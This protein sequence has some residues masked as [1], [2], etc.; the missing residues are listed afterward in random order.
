M[1]EQWKVYAKKADFVTL[2]KQLHVDPVIVRLI[3]NREVK[4]EDMETYLHPSFDH[5]HDPALLPDVQKGARI[6]AD[7]IK[8]GQKIRIIG[9]YDCDG[10]SA[11]YI[12]YH[13]LL[14]LG[15]Q[16]D[17][18]IPDRI[19]D[20]Y[21]LNLHLI[22][23]ALDDHVDTIITCDNGIAARDEI[24]YA[25]EHGMCVIVTDH[26]EVP[27]DEK[28]VNHPELLPEADAV[29]DPKRKGSSYPFE[30]IC[31]AVVA[32]KFLQVLYPLFGLEAKSLYRFI[33][34][35]ALATNCDVMP[36]T[37]ENRDIVALGL[38]EMNRT[39]HVGLR[40]LI[41]NNRIEQVKS[42]HLGFVI[43]PCINAAGRLETAEVAM[44]LLN[45]TDPEEAR[46]EATELIEVNNTRKAMTLRHV[47]EALQ[48]LETDAYRKDTVYVLHLP[49]CHE[50]LAGLVAGKIRERYYRPTLVLTGEGKMLKG[51]GRSIDAY[52]MFEKLSQC[53]DLFSKMGGHAQA[54]GFSLPKEN[55]QK[56]REFL[57]AHADLSSE[58]LV[59][60]RYLDLRMPISYLS[61]TLIRQIDLLEPFGNE[62]TKPSF[63]ENGALIL[64]A[65]RI[66]KNKNMLRFYLLADD[67]RKYQATYFGDADTFFA[68][69]CRR[70]GEEESAAIQNFKGSQKMT[71]CYH[72]S[73]DSYQGQSRI[74]IVID[75]FLDVVK[76]T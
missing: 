72:A 76:D 15:A 33:A 28:D 42:Y 70:F 58:D 14:D 34:F 46:K 26:H 30:E 68:A 12:L 74:S 61:E 35:A 67:G 43:G 69:V 45:E 59:E 37:N 51:S 2:S 13:G 41:D 18:A 24:A 7:K 29:I 55:L 1:S 21:G 38:K 3:R 71:F 5:L 48:L 52:S 32:M 20:G 44:K 57:N 64:G 36:L 47:E 56:L 19:T 8:E 66:G 23:V 54:A 31:G 39:R 62:N 17:Y 63:G 4:G 50:S 40:A 22:D 25:K 65:K 9:D 27:F 53:R 60:T 49:T 11:T 75:A 6:L 16:V 10:V 73:M